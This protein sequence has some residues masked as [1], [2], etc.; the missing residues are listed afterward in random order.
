MNINNLSKFVVLNPAPRTCFIHWSSISYPPRARC[1]T[2]RQAG[3]KKRQVQQ[4]AIL[5]QIDFVTDN[6]CD[7][8]NSSNRDTATDGADC[9]LL[10]DS[11]KDGIPVGDAEGGLVLIKDGILFGRAGGLPDVPDRLRGKI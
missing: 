6:L 10:L 9:G 4:L 3:V 2:Q 8:L 7:R 11:V 1:D 5:L